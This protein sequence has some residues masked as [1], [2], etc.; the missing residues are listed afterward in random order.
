MGTLLSAFEK[1]ESA[2]PTTQPARGGSLLDAFKAAEK[3]AETA[4]TAPDQPAVEPRG[5]LETFGAGAGHAVGR[6]VMGVQQ[7][8]GKGLSAA[9]EVADVGAL[10]TAGGWLERDAAAG[11]ARLEAENAPY[12]AANPKTSFAGEVTGFVASPI[13]RLIPAGPAA[14]TLTGA[15][16]KGAVQGAALNAL[17]SPVE[18]GKDFLPEKARQGGIGAL[19]GAAGGALGYTLAGVINKGIDAARSVF[20]RVSG[21][22]SAK[23]ADALVEQALRANGTSSAQVAAERPELFAGLQQMAADAVKS[24]KPVDP[25]AMVRLTRAQTL[26]VAVPMLKGQVTRD[27]MQ[28]A[29]EQNLRGIQG[30]GEPIVQTIQAQNKALI[31]NLN[32]MG[33]ARGADVVAAAKPVMQTLKAADDT[34]KSGVTK[35]YEAFKKSTGRSLDVPLPS[36]ASGYAKTSA[37]FGEAIPGAIR[38]K[39]EALGEMPWNARFTIEEAEALIKSINRNYDPKNLVSARALDELRNT[40]QKSIA[41]GAGASAEGTAAA[42][43]AKAARQAA[44]ERFALQDATPALK[45]VLRGDNPD[46]FLQ[47]Y[48]LQGNEREIGSMVRLLKA[49]DPKAAAGLEDSLMAHIKQRVLGGRSEENAA[50]SE[51]A[52]K[53]FIANPNMTARLQQVLSPERMA[54]LRQ[55]HL[56]AEDALYAPKGSAVNTSNTASAAAN[57]IKSEAKGGVL[58]ELLGITSRVLPVVG[59]TAETA[60]KAIQQNRISEMVSEAVNPSVAK[61]GEVAIRDLV[62]PGARAGA[63]ALAERNRRR[64]QP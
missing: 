17:T 38:K 24:G 64:A 43:L 53:E 3:K 46:K 5:K 10:R 39:F 52:L 33:A 60:Q 51:A 45:G 1:A 35:A 14:T 6:G 20:N 4:A 21:G 19:G 16:A 36:I 7:L 41:E 29:M 57:L 62:V 27:P 13:N 49:Q 37:E 55:L 42:G 40:V 2:A 11:A 61:K 47:K 50:F 12:R 54:Q 8:L 32:A 34:L 59:P 44:S 48:L 30:V 25:Q 56:V 58:N 23:A 18:E 26:P 15:V 22:N 9:G 28:F 63:G 31:E